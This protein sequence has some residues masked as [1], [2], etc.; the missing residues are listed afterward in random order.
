M[1]E[2]ITVI[3]RLQQLIAQTIARASEKRMLLV[4]GFRY[5][6]LDKSIRQS[7]DIDYHCEEDLGQTLK[8]LISLFQRR[9]LPEIRRDFGLEGT[10]FEEAKR[11]ESDMVK[12]ISLSFHKP[13]VPGSSIEILIDLLTIPCLDRPETR[14]K[15][16]SVYLTASDADM[17]ESKIL[18]LMSRIFFQ[19]RDLLDLFL[20][21]DFLLSDSAIRLQRKMEILH[22]QYVHFTELIESLEKNRSLHLKNLNKIIDEQVDRNMQ[23]D[24]KM[25]DGVNLIFDSVEKIL[26]DIYDQLKKG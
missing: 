13:G 12:T 25:N 5:R 4:G 16:G 6:L 1:D 3:E 22:L 17:V 10:V 18:A 15:G 14:T 21:K 8:S 19:D 20:F 7:M 26:S 24:L 23:A 9:L 11:E 2:E